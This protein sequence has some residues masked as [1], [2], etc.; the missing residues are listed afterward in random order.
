[1]ASINVGRLIGLIEQCFFATGS[2]QY[3]LWRAAMQEAER[4]YFYLIESGA[5]PQEARSVLPNSLKTEIVIT[6][7]AREWRHIFKQRTSNAA[8]PQMRELMTPL[9]A[10][11]KLNWPSL[12]SDILLEN[13]NG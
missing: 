12:F 13:H 4:H 2:Q 7:N 6:A 1:M 9:L 10:E 11:C 3:D 8:H 5:S